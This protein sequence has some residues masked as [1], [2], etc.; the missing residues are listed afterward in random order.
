MR[1]PLARS[2]AAG[3]PRIRASALVTALALT[4]GLVA[5][6]PAAAVGGQSVPPAGTETAAARDEAARAAAEARRTGKPVEILGQRTETD[7][8]WANPDGTKT[9]NRSLVPVR[10]R[11]SG[12]LIT[13]DST[14]QRGKDGRLAP[15]ATRIGLTFSG[16]GTAP[17]VVMSQ[18]GR[19]VSLSWPRPLPAPQLQGDSAVYPEV[20]PGVDL[21]VSASNDSFSHAL[22]VKTREAAANPALAS[23][24]FGLEGKGLTVRSESDGQLRAV[25]PSGQTVF[26]SAK[27]QMWDAGGRK[28][29]AQDGFRT[30]DPAPAG[31]P[32]HA[33]AEAAA[34]APA[35][36]TAEPEPTVP[37]AQPAPAAPLEGVT[38]G[39]KQADLGV[40][41][42]GKKLTLT[43]DQNLLRAPETTYPVVIDP[44]W[45]AW[46]QA[47]TIAYKHNAFPSSPNTNYW[48]GG[49][50]SKDARVGC[51]KDAANGNAVIC[52]KTFFQVGMTDF[53]DKQILEST[54]RVKQKSAGSWS[55]KSGDIQV[56]DT[57][58][59]SK[60]TTWNKQ[61]DWI[62]MVD[63]TGQSFGGRN[64][65]GDGDLIELNV[66]SAV[67]TAA[68][69]HW[70]NWT[71]GLKAAKDTVDVSWRKL[72]PN[73]ARIS[74]RFNTVPDKITERST[75]PS[76]PCTGGIIGTTD[77]IVLRARLKDK[78]KED[79]SLSAEFH[80]WKDGA[81]TPTKVLRTASN[82]S[83]AQLP[84]PAKGLD[85]TYRWDV[86]TVDKVGSTGPWAGQCVFTIDRTRPDKT[87]SVKSLQFP[88]NE[89]DPEKTSFTRTQG[90]FTLGAG[91]V[92]DVTAFEWWTDSNPKVNKAS[93]TS[94]GGSVD[95]VYTPT[96]AGPQRLFVHSL[97]A[98]GNRSNLKEYLF[99]A[100]RL[101][102]RDK[103]GDLNG[104][105]TV[106]IWSVDP[107][108]GTLW[109][110]P[111]KGDGTFDLSRQLDQG[112]FADSVSLAHRGS[113]NEDYY[114]DLVVLR[115]GP[116]GAEKKLYVYPNKGDGDL[117]AADANRIE[118]QVG[119]PDED[120]HWKNADQVVAIGSVNDDNGDGRTDDADQPD[121]LVRTGAEL[122]LYL[123]SA[124]GF[125]DAFSAPVAL[126]N[127]DWANMTIMAPGDLNGDH[128][129]EV[130]ARDTAT[131][132]IHQYTSRPSTEPGATTTADLAVFGDPAVRGS[133]IATG[134][135]GA[136]Y[137]HLSTNGDFETDGFADLWSR[138]GDGLLTEFPGRAPAGGSAFAAGR[139]LVLG[140]TSWS[141]CQTF[142]STAT[143]THTLCGPILSKYLSKGG[144]SLG[145][146]TT[147]VLVPADGVGRYVNL[148]G[149]GQT[150]DNGSI[151][152]HPSSGAWV[153][154]GAIRAKWLGMGAEKGVMGYPTSDEATN[155]DG[156]GYHST[157]S[158]TAGGKGGIYWSPE[159]GAWSVHGSVYDK[160]ASL[161]GP[162]SPLGYPI[163]DETNIGDGAAVRYNHFRKRSD[164][165]DTGSLYWTRAGG[166]WSV[167]G[168]IRKKWIAL[169]ADKSTL[170][171]P[172]SDEYEVAGGPREDFQKGYIRHNRVTGTTQEH[173][174][175]DRTAALRTDL[176]G[177]FNGDGRTDIATAYDWG[178]NTTALYVF[179]ALP[180]GG[181]AEPTL[182]WNSAKGGFSYAR[183]KW[184]AA[185]FNGD[186]HTDI[187]GWYGYEDGSTAWW[188]FA[189]NATGTFTPT[190]SVTVA[191]GVYNWAKSQPLAGDFN[192][193]RR[194]DLALV[195]DYGGG[196]MGAHTWTA[197]T[198]GTFN[199]SVASWRT[200]P[201]KWWI[202]YATFRVGDMNGDGRDDFLAMYG[203]ST[204]GTALFTGLAQPNGGFAA[205]VKHWA[206]PAGVWE[207]AQTKLTVGDYNG[208]GRDDAALMY[209]HGDGHASLDTLLGKADGTVA[210]T[211]RSWD[212]PEGNWYASNAG[213]P[214]SGD[215]DGDGRADVV[216]LYNYASGASG[217]FTFKSRTD[218]GFEN[219]FLSWQ[220]LPGTW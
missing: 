59:I 91:G 86:R 176:S 104:D 108:S 55:C 89:D 217:T 131:G 42:A 157:F 125:L 19:S 135:T 117:E 18:N 51:A 80:Y 133:A 16:G 186:G 109:L 181:F 87:P 22:V 187:G 193:D 25:D 37:A 203:Y 219:G 205:P 10:V 150:A 26:G 64:C 92:K 88:E 72:D 95:V 206:K 130:W 68:Q 103:P 145:Y 143:G 170:G 9:A 127:A 149:A 212:T 175:A 2:R 114:E 209:D 43:P 199:T 215:S 50:L 173:L 33:F 21:R 132:K 178:D 196:D 162:A 4:A 126:G 211:V 17:L 52:A 156:V 111:G 168:S 46:K 13:V 139:R 31:S 189:S 198:D 202:D 218:G 39:A 151:Y 70:G 77:Q 188:T 169:G 57:G 183:V 12:K 6:V 20:L 214:M 160:Y 120:D 142:T 129:P 140:G 192:G 107:G 84:I 98:S 82:G 220:A 67:A 167:Y 75:D 179:D 153:V 34:Q 136:A 124:V 97:D 93:P 138:G 40:R 11:Q 8:I 115:P 177:D 90:T 118:L 191:K 5:V 195:H 45:D 207:Y 137:P 79:T 154:W 105:G 116:D 216:T 144:T 54:L 38:T 74:V 171:F 152:W 122:W 113:W 134:F 201:G 66:K 99:Y 63:A 161:G 123:G 141:E 81:P 94:P 165:A 197:K 27:P 147:D 41:L 185:D 208:D 29:P 3:R 48:N 83:V 76:V 128:L 53:W 155:F 159:T 172:V 73:S 61:P 60:S 182:R 62:R 47:W 30:Q 204:Y 166:T 14:L 112:S 7:D 32:A 96:T 174:P 190:K 58:S 119:N 210:E 102:T 164:T 23:L 158:S 121:L 36:R 180:D 78:D 146:P 24:D 194:G 56:W 35:P 213:M 44:T 101:G 163:T 65:P 1:P 106:D 71:F 184:V 28:T 85:G 15:K 148:R 69:K 100:K 49:T 110:H 200:G